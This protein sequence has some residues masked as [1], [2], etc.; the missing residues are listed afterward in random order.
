MGGRRLNRF[1]SMP[2]KEKSIHLHQV[3]VKT[4]ISKTWTH[5]TKSISMA[6]YHYHYIRYK[7]CEFQME[8]SDRSK[9]NEEALLGSDSNV[10]QSQCS[11]CT[12]EQSVSTQRE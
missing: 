12:G 4:A 5:T 11:V 3:G 9:T 7:L 6:R 8:I 1:F 10:T 2:H